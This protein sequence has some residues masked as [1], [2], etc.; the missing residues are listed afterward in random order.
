MIKFPVSVIIFNNY[1]TVITKGGQMKNI[2]LKKII[3]L[4]I[5]LSVFSSTSACSVNNNNKPVQA[6]ESSAQYSAEKNQPQKNET[7][8][9]TDTSKS[10]I[11][12][13]DPVISI[14]DDSSDTYDFPDEWQDN[15]IFS[16]KYQRAYEIVKNMSIEEKVGQI[17][18]ARCPTVDAVPEAKKFHLGGYVLFGRDIDGKTK[19]KI[20][21]DVRS[22]IN[23][24]DIPMVIATDEEGGTVSRLSLNDELTKTPFKSPREL[25]DEGGLDAIIEDT[26]N[27]CR[28]MKSL[29]IDTNLAPVCDI[30]KTEG[31]F[32]Y[33]RSLGQNPDITSDYVSKF[34]KT[35]QERGISVTLKHFPGYGNNPDTHTSYAV[36]KRTYETFLNNDFLPFKAGIEA[37][38]HIVLVSHNIVECMDKNNPASL[39]PDVHEILRNELGFTGIIITDDLAMDAIGKYVTDSSP[40]IKAVKAGNDMICVSDYVTAYNDIL[41][42]VNNEMIDVK[43]IDHAVMRIL[44]WKMVKNML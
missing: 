26:K 4:V 40:Y 22:Y 21:G 44:A 32:M 27:K 36:D 6:S 5:A 7:E 31:D 39:S 11:T 18:L 10:E 12:Q 16:A 23:C 29:N 8:N 17:I 37:G 3:A 30:S 14:D 20:A 38:A 19:S 42:A 15:G 9:S 25:F 34:T 33:D 43:L 2:G 41:Y 35:S 24:Q 1:F 13:P 28:L